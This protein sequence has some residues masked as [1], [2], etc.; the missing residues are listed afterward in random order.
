MRD[1]INQLA[2][3]TYTFS[4]RKKTNEEKP[5]LSIIINK[6]LDKKS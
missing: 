4:N 5:S 2:E 1:D 6:N 3:D